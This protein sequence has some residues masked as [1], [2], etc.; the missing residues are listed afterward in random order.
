MSCTRMTVRQVWKSG[1]YDSQTS[2][3]ST[4]KLLGIVTTK[5]R[6]QLIHGLKKLRLTKWARD[7]I[8]QLKE[9]NVMIINDKNTV[10][11]IVPANSPAYSPAFISLL[12]PACI[13]DTKMQLEQPRVRAGT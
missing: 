9:K 8:M 13:C 3:F 11:Y 4:G 12:I 6:S 1:K 2:N 7:T 10:S 5:V